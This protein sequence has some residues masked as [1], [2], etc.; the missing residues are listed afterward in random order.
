ML[1][2]K[3][4]AHQQWNMLLKRFGRLDV[5]SKFE[6][7]DQ[8]FSE[9][10][11]D[12]EDASCYISVFENGR[13]RDA[14]MGG[15]L[16]PNARPLQISPPS[17][18]TTTVPP[19]AFEEVTAAFSE[20]ANQQRGQLKLARPGSKYA[21][22]VS[23][24]SASFERKTNPTTGVRIHKQNPKGVPCKN[25]AC[26]GLPHYMT[27]DREHCMETGGGMETKAPW[28]A[29]RGGKKKDVAA[30][31]TE[32]KPPAPTPPAY[33][34]NNTTETSALATAHTRDWSCAVI[35]EVDP[36]CVPSSEDIACIAGQTLSTILDS[37]TTSTLITS[38]QY[39]WTYTVG[40]NVTISLS[41]SAHNTFGCMIAFMPLVP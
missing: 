20:E 10:L 37:G 12:A 11:K 26:I 34:P 40:S 9:C 29:Q 3:L 15:I 32:S 23:G 6:L 39:F 14:T 33:T 30:S 31:A 41:A 36:S 8:L 22:T 18:S 24:S 2:E 27:H 17:S 19:V 13:R 1:G 25:P 21:N 35:E 4:M 38:R 28:G 5:T 16:Q 7:H